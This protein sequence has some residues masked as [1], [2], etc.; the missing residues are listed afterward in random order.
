MARLCCPIQP[1]IFLRL[2]VDG[3]KSAKHKVRAMMFA[4]KTI[5]KT[6]KPPRALGDVRA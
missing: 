5:T 4:A 1:P 2:Q 6:T 3:G